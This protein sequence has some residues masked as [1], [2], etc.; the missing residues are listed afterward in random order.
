ME[1]DE[2]CCSILQL[3]ILDNMEVNV[4]AATMVTTVTLLENY[5]IRIP[6]IIENEETDLDSIVLLS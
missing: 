3:E 6:S 2:K 4:T 1:Y 5:R